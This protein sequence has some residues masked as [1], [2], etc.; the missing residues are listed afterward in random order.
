MATNLTPKP[1]AYEYPFEEEVVSAAKY[2]AEVPRENQDT[3]GRVR[4]FTG[5]LVNPLAMHPVDIDIRDIAHQLSNVCRYTGATPQFYSVAQHSVLV[6]RYFLDSRKRL[7]GLLHD[8][9]EAYLNDIASPVKRNVIFEGYRMAEKKLSLEIF[10]AF[11][12]DARRDDLTDAATRQFDDLMFEREVASF[13][14]PSG[15]VPDDQR[16][17]PWSPA[18]AEK[19]FLYEFKHIFR[20]FNGE[21]S[22]RGL[23]LQ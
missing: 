19:E 14:G 2:M 13:W 12:L 17:T 8:A 15:S 16:V 23:E 18:K 7:V 11:G 20:G 22:G 3:A 6:A 4:T 5:K 10:A 1:S 21:E 9:S